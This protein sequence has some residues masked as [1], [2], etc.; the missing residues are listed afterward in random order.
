[1]RGL[2]AVTGGMVGL[3]LAGIA[4]S[5]AKGASTV[6]E[7]EAACAAVQVRARPHG[8]PG[9]LS[10]EALKVGVEA[11]LLGFRAGDVI[12]PENFLP[13]LHPCVVAG[14]HQLAPLCRV[15]VFRTRYAPNTDQLHAVRVDLFESP[16]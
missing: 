10:D 9:D 1:M 6:H 13:N 2:P 14:I 3:L 15:V 8:S 7:D 16:A 11:G 5:V 4:L 12:R